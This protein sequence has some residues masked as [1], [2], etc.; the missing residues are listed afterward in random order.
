MKTDMVRTFG[1][2]LKPNPVPA[3]LIHTEYQAASGMC[4]K[5]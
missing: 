4:N 5:R 1:R 3:F 2:R